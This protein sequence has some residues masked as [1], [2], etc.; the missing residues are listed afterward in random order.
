MSGVTRLAGAIMGL[1]LL[2]GCAARYADVPTPTRFENS[3]QNK[4][5]AA[6]HWQVIADNFA[7]QIS[8]DLRKQ[9]I[10]QPLYIAADQK[11]YAFVE[12][13]RELL[14]TAMVAQGWDMRT[15]SRKALSVDI[16]YSIYKFQPERLKNVYYHGEATALVAGLWAVSGIVDSGMSAG[17]KALSVAVLADGASWF[18]QEAQNGP[19]F[20]QHASGPVP[21]SEIIVTASINDGDKIVA[22]RSNIYFTVDEDK[23][24]YWN[25]PADA[26][27]MRLKGE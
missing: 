21:Q 23:S 12:G 26:P 18:A 25:K 4:L 20:G 7:T 15:S 19:K 13:F 22:R 17:A 10:S 1:A 5:Q 11:D 14:T 8:D 24:L 3:K 9:G 16:R 27:V 2:S 6:A